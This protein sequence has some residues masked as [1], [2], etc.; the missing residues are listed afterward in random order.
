MVERMYGPE[1]K[2]VLEYMANNGS[3]VT[4]EEIAKALGYRVNIVRKAL[5]LLLEQNMVVY[6]RTRSRDTGWYVYYWKIND[7]Q[8][9]SVLQQRKK[10]VLKKLRE[11]LA[12]EEEN[13]FFICPNDKTRYTFDEALENDFICPRCGTPLIEYDNSSIVMFLKKKIQEIE[14]DVS[15]FKPSQE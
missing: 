14:K 2:K 9:E 1:V 15:S 8:L 11:R 3:E 10:E 5:Y 6:R 4:D 13:T 7:E 12:Y